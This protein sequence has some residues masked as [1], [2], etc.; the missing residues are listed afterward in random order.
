MLKGKI[1]EEEMM[2]MMDR[3]K[4]SKKMM[5]EVNGCLWEGAVELLGRL[6]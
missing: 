4:K 6:R 3:G 5:M 2:E 1:V